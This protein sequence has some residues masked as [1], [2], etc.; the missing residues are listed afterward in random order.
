MEK[1][2]RPEN[3]PLLVS[4]KINRAVWNQLKQKARASDKALQKV[5]QC[6]IAA[7]SAMINA[8]EKAT[9]DVKTTL[10]HGLVLALAG[11][12]ELNLRRRDQLRPELN[13]QF[14]SLCNVATPISSELFGDDPR[15]EVEIKQVTETTSP[16]LQQEPVLF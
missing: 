2:P 15:K 9:G 3:C 6:F 10:T 11:N 7:V 8:C 1:Y 5:Q 14:A 16:L 4:P 13:A 12:R